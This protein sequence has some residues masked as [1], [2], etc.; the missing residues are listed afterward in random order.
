VAGAAV[1]ALDN[2]PETVE[3]VHRET[4]DGREVITLINYSGG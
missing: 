2:A 1:I 3:V 4:A